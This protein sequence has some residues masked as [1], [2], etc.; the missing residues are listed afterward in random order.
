MNSTV[1]TEDTPAGVRVYADPDAFR[2]DEFGRTEY[3]LGC[4]PRR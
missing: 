2:R 1:T 3:W 4:R